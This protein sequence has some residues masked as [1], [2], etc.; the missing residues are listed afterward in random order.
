MA[1]FEMLLRDRERL[2]E[3]RRRVNVMPLGSAAL[4]GTTFPID[5]AFTA[6]ELG[7]EAVSENSLDAVSDRDFAIEF[8][9]AAS[10]AM[11]H[12][13]RWSEELVL[14]SSP[15]VRLRR[16]ARP[17]LHRLVDHAAEEESRRAGAGARQN[18]PRVRPPDGLA[19]R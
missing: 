12:L 3:L 10:I 1:W 17:L 6:R 15:A 13:S 2:V 11:M 19:R 4:A 16:P 7:F 8:C 14:W 18:R 5:R 9:S